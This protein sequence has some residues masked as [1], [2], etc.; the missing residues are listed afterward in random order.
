[1]LRHA[2]Y[3]RAR[4]PGDNPIPPTCTG[5]QGWRHA[6]D[7]LAPS[8]SRSWTKLGGFERCPRRYHAKKV[9]EVCLGQLFCRFFETQIKLIVERIVEQK[10]RRPFARRTTQ[11]ALGGICCVVFEKSV[12]VVTGKSLC[13]ALV[14]IP[15]PLSLVVR[16]ITFHGHLCDGAH[17]PRHNGSGGRA[18]V[19][20]HQSMLRAHTVGDGNPLCWNGTAHHKSAANFLR[21]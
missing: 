15:P 10:R 13:G 11:S 7:G 6:L 18:G 21:K 17:L 9:I 4:L 3:P 1:M 14:G 12:F 8:S 2:P 16:R 19:P 5:S 20:T